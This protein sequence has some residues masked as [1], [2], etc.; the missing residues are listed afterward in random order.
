MNVLLTGASGTLG[1]DLVRSLGAAGAE[2]TALSR[3]ER[4][5]DDG[6]RWV[7]GDLRS[8]EGLEAAVSGS[9]VIVHA[10]TD[11][12]A[13]GGK[14]RARYMFVHPRA[15]DVGGTKR[16][17]DVARA[18]GV[19]HVVFVSIVGVD[20]VPYGYWKVKLDAE[21]V[22]A[23]AGVP[24][25]IA[26]VTQFHPFVDSLLRFA[27]RSPLPMIAGT[28]P[29]Q[30][31]DPGDAAAAIASIATRDPAGGIVDIG[32]PEVLTAA[33]AADAWLAARGSRRRFRNVRVAGRMMHAVQAGGLLTDDR[34]GMITWG[35]WLAERGGKS[36]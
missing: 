21:R 9:T 30:P 29:V 31:I 27:L 22:V 2:V 16:L 7:R 4:P 5:A 35:D 20:R 15:T 10:A 17:L 18:A 14:I 36:G 26:R 33:D 25:T 11:G 32:G 6:A 13:A 34:T 28:L 12:G 8:G 1:R 24:Y 19:A 23:D 3:R